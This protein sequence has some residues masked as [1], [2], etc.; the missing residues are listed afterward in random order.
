MILR[1][2]P[3]ALWDSGYTARYMKYYAD[4][5]YIDKEANEVES[6]SSVHL[7]PLIGLNGREEEN[8]GM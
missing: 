2:M 8:L 4:L 5:L 7:L 3:N 6:G 1:G